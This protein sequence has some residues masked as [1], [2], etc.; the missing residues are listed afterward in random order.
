MGAKGREGSGMNG[1]DAIV[2]GF[3]VLAWIGKIPYK[4]ADYDKPWVLIRMVLGRTPSNKALD[5]MRPYILRYGLTS[6]SLR[7]RLIFEKII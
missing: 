4:M 6:L 2:P 1:K 3:W 7:D 5:A